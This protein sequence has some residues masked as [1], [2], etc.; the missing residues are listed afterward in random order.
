MAFG[1]GS[2][3]E[4]AREEHK[5]RTYTRRSEDVELRALLKSSAAKRVLSWGFGAACSI[6]AFFGGQMK[7]QRDENGS[8]QR[9]LNTARWT[10][11]SDDL[12]E[13]IARDEAKLK[14]LEDDNASTKADMKDLTLAT[15]A[16]TQALERVIDRLKKLKE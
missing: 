16:N 5:P 4:P 10:A 2:A 6:A 13:R 12:R 1:N 15:R 14:W 3:V 11:Y 7:A 9:E 8:L